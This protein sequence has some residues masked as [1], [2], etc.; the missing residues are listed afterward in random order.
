[1]AL[2]DLTSRRVLVMGLGR[3]GGG[4]G[5]TH[6][7]V[8]RGARVTVTDLMPAEKL[9]RSIEQIRG[10]P[11]ELRLGE[12]RV[13]DFQEADLIVVNP[14]VDLRDNVFLRAAAEAGVPTTTEI[15]LLAAALPNRLRTIG[16]TGSA[17][18]S[19][20][21]AMIGHVLRKTL[22][23]DRVH[24]G[25]NL[26]GSLLGGIESIR[27][28]DWVVLELS[29]FMLEGLETDRWSPHL[30]VV[31][32]LT[33]NHLDRH[34]SM[35]AY[36]A[37]KQA[38]VRH[39][40]SGDAALLGPGVADWPL[41]TGVWRHVIDY[42]HYG[43]PL[44][45][46]GTHNQFNAA[47]AL[48]AARRVLGDAD[49]A[50]AVADFPGLPHRLQFVAERAEVRYYNDS[51]ATTPEATRLALESFPPGIVHVILGGHDKGSDLT[52]VAQFAAVHCRAIYTIGKTGDAIAD[53]A[54]IT[55]REESPARP[56]SCGGITWP[57]SDQAEVIRC[58]TL[59]NTMH[60]MISRLRQGDVVLLSTACASWDQ[61]ENY[62]QRGSRFAELVLQHTGEGAPLPKRPRAETQTR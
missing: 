16:V 18:K 33:P 34:G 15:R 29:S 53:A 2:P 4:V 48:A 22:G 51:K 54:E 46:P 57:A 30:A 60:A 19:T 44:L 41:Q 32:N 61:F 17:G 9:A 39:Q 38:I 11:V 37:I 55:R 21:T 45:V 5:V 40:E 26:G 14:A 3:F 42:R 1:M 35:E 31:T 6:F 25:G 36:A 56:A 59:E 24:V 10:L 58:G 47:L 43:L 49:H 50:A 12:H 52:S 62:E 7:L 8:G 27:E 28:D 20:T 23:E 13:R